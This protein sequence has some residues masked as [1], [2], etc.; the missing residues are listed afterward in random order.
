MK[1]LVY[2]IVFLPLF[3]LSQTLTSTTNIDIT[4]YW[5]QETSGYTYPMNIFVPSGDVPEG[6]FPIC[7]LLHGNGGNGG[8]M[9]NQFKNVLEWNY[10]SVLLIYYLLSRLLWK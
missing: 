8:D 1:K 10:F 7:I 6:G 2:I 4:K 5:H 3:T 9:I